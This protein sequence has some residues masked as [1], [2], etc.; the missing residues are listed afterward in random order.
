VRVGFIT[1]LLW[2]RY[3]AFWYRLV[4]ASGTPVLPE[5][6]V[7]LQA[8]GDERLEVIPGVAFRLA[9][10]QAIALHDCDVIIAPDLNAGEEGTRGGA[11]DPWI[12]SF[13]DAL[14]TTI[15]GLPP[16]IA[17]P[18]SLE[19]AI[20]PLAVQTLHRLVHDPARVKRVWAQH[21]GRIRAPAYREPRWY[22]RPNQ[23]VI[24]LMAQPWLMDDALARRL[25]D[26]ESVSVAQ[27][28][29]EPARLRLEGRRFDQRLIATD[30]EVLGAARLFSRKGS[31]TRMLLVV[32]ESSA[33]DRWLRRQVEAMASKPLEVRTLREVVGDLTSLLAIPAA[34]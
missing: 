12:A 28:Q 19:P 32:D 34:P 11:Q 29:L 31:I 15:G 17:V 25:Q 5:R 27:H 24:G 14:A 18:A 7:T 10:A 8:L 1:Q 9:A 4:E 13:P 22:G 16:I 33:S 30:S 21:R 20:E 6:E 26:E 3:G 23:E 2:S